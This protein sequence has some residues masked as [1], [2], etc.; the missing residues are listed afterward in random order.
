MLKIVITEYS[1]ESTDDALGKAMAKASRY[2]S[3]DQDV[4]VSVKELAE[5]PGQGFRATVEVTIVPISLRNRLKVESREAEEKREREAEYRKQLEKLEKHPREL[6]LSHFL[7]AMGNWCPEIPDFMITDINDATILRE[8]IEH[9][10]LHAAHHSNNHDLPAP[11]PAAPHLKDVLG[12]DPHALHKPK[13]E[14]D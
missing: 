7:E 8:D 10:F 14:P 5:I 3:G 4:H 6:V 1:R 11:E 13:P 2:L 12:K 9:T